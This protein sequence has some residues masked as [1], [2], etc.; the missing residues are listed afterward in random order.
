VSLDVDAAAPRSAR[1]LGVFGR[2]HLGVGLA[3]PLDQ[4]L[5]HD[6]TRRHVDAESQRLGGEDRPDETAHEQLLDDLLEGRQHACVVGSHAAL[7]AVEPVVVAQDAPVVFGDV[8]APLLHDGAD[9]V[10]LVAGCQ[11]QPCGHALHDRRIA[12]GAAEYERDRGQQPLAL[13]PFEHLD[14]AWRVGAAV[15]PGAVPTTR[16]TAA[17]SA[18][19]SAVV[20]MAQQLW[21]DPAA[22]IARPLDEQVHEPR[23]DHDVLP[24]WYRTALLD[25]HVRIA[26]NGREPVTEFFGV[27]HS[28]R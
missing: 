11:P 2:S 19:G 21:V 14:A 28:R 8:C 27:G 9:L 22:A 26:A 18:S 23:A 16:W 7:E 3:V 5:E 15:A 17:A 10:R 6:R 1:Q 12:A 25:D 20:C 13:E 24:Q 4:P